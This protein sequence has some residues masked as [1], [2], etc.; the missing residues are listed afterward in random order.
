ML[1]RLE[2]EV[3]GGETGLKVLDGALQRSVDALLR[4]KDRRRLI[5]DVDSTEDPAHGSQERATYNGY[6]GTNCFHPCLPS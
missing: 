1:S 6:F 2:N 4:E 3:L 5:V